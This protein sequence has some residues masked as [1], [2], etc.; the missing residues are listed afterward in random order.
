LL[1]LQLNQ[2]LS[3]LQ[4]FKLLDLPMLVKFHLVL[5]L[6]WSTSKQRALLLVVY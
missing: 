6:L 5:K 2:L 1:V 4:F 3:K